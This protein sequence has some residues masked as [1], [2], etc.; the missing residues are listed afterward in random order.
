MGIRWNIKRKCFSDRATTFW[1]GQ[2]I[3]VVESQSLV[4]FEERGDGALRVHGEV[5]VGLGDL[6][7]FYQL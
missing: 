2:F 3:E 6:R 1:N 5:G 4:V 7:G